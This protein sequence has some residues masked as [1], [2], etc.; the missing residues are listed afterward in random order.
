MALLTCSSIQG[1][2]RNGCEIEAG[3]LGT[4]GVADEI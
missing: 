2:V 1:L 3:L 4:P